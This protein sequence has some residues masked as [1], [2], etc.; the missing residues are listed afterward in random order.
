MAV[1]SMPLPDPCPHCGGLLTAQARDKA[2]CVA[3]GSVVQEGLLVK[4]GS[5][6]DAAAEGEEAAP[7]GAASK[8][9][10]SGAG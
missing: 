2:K 4:V 8:G 3:C 5:L 1:W 6:P 7:A 10:G 9:N